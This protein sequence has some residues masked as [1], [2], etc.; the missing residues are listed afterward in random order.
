MELINDLTDIPYDPTVKFASFDITNM[1]PNVPTKELLKIINIMC[2]KHS[3]N[4]KLK[5]E[6]TKISQVLIEQNYFRFHDTIY[7]QNEGLATGAPTSS[8]LSEIY[9]DYM[10]NTEICDVLLKHQVEGYF[11]Y[12]DGI[13]IMHKESKTNIYEILSLFINIMPNMKFTLEEEKENRVN[14]LDITITKN[15]D[16]LSFGIYRKPT[17]TDTIIPNDLCHPREH[18][19]AAIIYLSNRMKMYNLNPQTKRK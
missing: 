6:I 7:V 12:V 9:L 19:L 16:N 13:L 14:F 5:Q 10:K 17:T 4:D 1:Y 8:I 18:K 11:R 3:L 15:D 2:D